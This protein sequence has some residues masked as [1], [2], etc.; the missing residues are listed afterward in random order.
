VLTKDHPDPV[1]DQRAP[2]RR[3]KTFTPAGQKYVPSIREL[4]VTNV[5]TATSAGE[6]SRD[7]V[8]VRVADLLREL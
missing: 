8:I 2:P 7:G 4:A 5:T 1:L 3:Q 6:E